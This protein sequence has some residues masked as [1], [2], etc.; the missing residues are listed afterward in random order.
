MPSPHSMR[1]IDR[2][3]RILRSATLGLAGLLLMPGQANA[4]TVAATGTLKPTATVTLGTT[5]SGAVQELSC[6]VNAIVKKGQ[7]CAQIDPRPFQRVI[8]V[9]RAELATAVAQFEQHMASFTQAKA[10]YQRNAALLERGLVTKA[11][12]EGL[13]STYKQA[14]AQIDYHRAIID[15][16]KAQLSA[17]E[18]N[19]S[20]T[21]INAPIDGTVLER[22]IGLGETVPGSYGP[23][24]FV[25]ASDL[26][27]MHAIVRIDETEIG[28]FRTA[29]QAK[30][31]VKAFPNQKFSGK[32]KQ[33]QFVP[34]AAGS[35][36]SYEVVVE[37][38]NIE[39]YLR[40]G[41][42]VAVEVEVTG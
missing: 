37:V 15:Q 3:S 10:A 27:K 9:N 29:D 30:L 38:D 36:V 14:Q 42:S 33:V 18:L 34:E 26:T 41:M 32:V 16:R 39:L 4:R 19:L 40:P 17:A 21:R 25:I 13:K 8:E 22:R 6:E 1:S 11:S 20:Y 7:T 24:L 2:L 12:Y 31:T 23:G 28:A 5:V 35:M